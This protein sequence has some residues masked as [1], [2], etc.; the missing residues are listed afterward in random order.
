MS[1]F[2]ISVGFRYYFWFLRSMQMI[3]HLP[4]F[5]VIFPGNI[6]LFIELLTPIVQ[7]DI[8]PAKWSYEYIY[9]FDYFRYRQLEGFI[10]DQMEDI[11]YG[12]HNAVIILG[13]FFFFGIAFLAAITFYY[14]ATYILRKIRRKN[15]DIELEPEGGK[16]QISEEKS[17]ELEGGKDQIS[18]D[19]SYYLEDLEEDKGHESD[20]EMGMVYDNEP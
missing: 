8:I 19:R 7:F 5:K 13:S 14:V 15:Y 11:G 20:L 2:A 3:I 17:V 10:L 6:C 18:D 9:D 1:L 4:M 12:T 16:E